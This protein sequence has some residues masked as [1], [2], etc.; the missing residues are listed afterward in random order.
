LGGFQ[1]D[2]RPFE[3]VVLLDI[4]YGYWPLVILGFNL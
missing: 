3:V 2:K 4:G 1:Y